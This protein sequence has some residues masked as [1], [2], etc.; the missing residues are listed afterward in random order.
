MRSHVDPVQLL[1]GPTRRLKT[2][3]SG[4]AVYHLPQWGRAGDVGR[5]AILRRL[6]LPYARDPQ[7]RQ[8]A[9]GILRAA[10]VAPRD[11]RGQ[12]AAILRWLQNPQNVYYLNE[13][14]ELLQ[15]PHRTLTSKQGDCDDLALL[16][17]ALLE[18]IRL[19]TRFVLSGRGRNGRMIRWVEGTKPPR[20]VRW[21]HIYLLVRPHPFNPA[22][23]LAFEP[24]LPRPLGWDVTQHSQQGRSA[25]PELGGAYGEGEPVTPEPGSPLA[26]VRGLPWREIAIATIPTVLSAVLT[27]VVLNSLASR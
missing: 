23:L 26:V 19:P 9:V 1:G 20:G 18:S 2:L 7:I 25:L 11:Y 12:A 24:T 4:E 22:P 27:A 3:P 6:T 16:G 8:V 13:P 17:A 5:V 10:R 14:G 21:S 15:S